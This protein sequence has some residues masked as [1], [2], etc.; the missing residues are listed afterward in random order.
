[1][2]GDPIRLVIENLLFI[3]DELEQADRLDVV[4]EADIAR[5][6]SVAFWQRKISKANFD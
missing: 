3:V 2:C 6:S 5:A 1:M 4:Y